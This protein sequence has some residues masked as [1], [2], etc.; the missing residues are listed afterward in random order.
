MMMPLI[1]VPKVLAFDT[2]S[3]RGSVALLEGGDL[4]AELR[5]N[6]LQTHSAQLL[7]SIEFL[8]ARVGWSLS[9]LNLVAVGMGPGSFT[10]IRIGIATAI[11]FAQSLAIPFAG[12]SGLDALAHQCPFPDGPV[13]V[14]LDAHRSQVFYGEYLSRKGRIRK[15]AKPSLLHVSDLERLLTARHT[16]IVGD[17]KVC[18]LES[19]AGWP[20]PVFADLFLAASMGRLALSRKRTW[21]SGDWSVAEPLYIRPPDAIKNKSRKR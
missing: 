6:S 13:G 16:Y 14:V 4:R 1:A 19:W 11:G 8:L 7:S 18:G 21:R 5:L 12:V 9:N 3:V 2:S 17:I 15:T 20:H 10:G